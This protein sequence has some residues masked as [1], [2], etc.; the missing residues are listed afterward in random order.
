[1]LGLLYDLITVLAWG[2]WLAPSQNIPFKNQQIKTFYV[3]TANLALAIVVT[4]AQ[5]W[6]GMT[7]KVFW[8][9]FIGGLV[10]AVSGLCAFTAT[11]KIGLAKA[12]GLWAPLNIIT[13]LF[14]G[15]VLFD[16]FI[17]L[18]SGNL[19]LLFASVAIILTG[20]VMIIFTRG[21]NKSNQTRQGLLVGLL[22]AVGAGILW[23]SYF[24]PIKFSEV[25]MWLA[26]FPLA[27]GIFVGSA[28]LA[29]ISRQPLRLDKSSH[30]LRVSLTG[31]LWGIG[32][33]GML[34]L[35][36]QLGA[37]KGFTIAQLSVVVNALIGI[38]ILRDPQPKTRAATLTLLGCILATIGGIILGNLK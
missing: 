37:G 36:G 8:P 33:Y 20:V 27:V 30:Y 34:L 15:G 10:W 29:L 26:A 16:E 14:W 25:S 22:G 13:S 38:Y 23:G 18:S 2:T 35:V 17:H 11:D 1:M 24:I 3:A 6:S 19:A 12:F 32:N 21:G 5:G 7:A 4:L 9:P 28:V 31:I